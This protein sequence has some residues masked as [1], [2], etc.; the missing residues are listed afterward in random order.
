MLICSSLS[1]S[2]VGFHPLIQASSKVANLKGSPRQHS[3]PWPALED[4]PP[5]ARDRITQRLEGIDVTLQGTHISHLGKRKTIFKSA[6]RWDMLVPRRVM[7]SFPI[8]SSFQIWKLS[9]FDIAT[10]HSSLQHD[11]VLWVD[12]LVLQS[13]EGSYIFWQGFQL[14]SS[15]STVT[16]RGKLSWMPK[17][18]PNY[19]R[20]TRMMEF[21]WRGHKLTCLDLLVGSWKKFQNYSPKWCFNGDL[22]WYQLKKHLKQIQVNWFAWLLN[23]Q[24]SLC[25]IHDIRSCNHAKRTKHVWP[26]Q[27][28]VHATCVAQEDIGKD[29]RQAWRTAK[30]T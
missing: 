13:H 15:L 25:Q 14:Y 6:F 5:S 26:L 18:H 4:F 20:P 11:R 17:K 22:P 24:L 27:R 8:F 21:I 7:Y 28:D 23:Q 30:C 2:Q 16:V 9:E 19:T 1:T 29:K 3:N 12:W 10:T